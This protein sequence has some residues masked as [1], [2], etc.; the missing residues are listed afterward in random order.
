MDNNIDDYYEKKYLKYKQKY[1]KSV[2][3]KCNQNYTKELSNLCIKDSKGKYSDKT[4]CINKCTN[5]QITIS[6]ELRFSRLNKYKYIQKKLNNKYKYN[7]FEK[8]CIGKNITDIV[9]N[10]FISNGVN[11][12]VYIGTFNTEKKKNIYIAI[13]KQPLSIDE[14][15]SE[16]ILNSTFEPWAEIYAMKAGNKLFEQNITPHVS[17]LY[18]YFICDECTYENE[19]LREKSNNNC[20][21]IINELATSDLHYWRKQNHTKDEWYIMLFQIIYSLLAFQ[22]TYNLSHGDLHTK[23]ILYDKINSY[24][25]YNKY[26][27]FGKTIIIKNNMY[28]F[29]LYDFAKATSPNFIKNKNY[30]QDNI[31]K[32]RTK[33]I[34]K[35][36]DDLINN[37][38]DDPTII[39]PPEPIKTILHD[40]YKYFLDINEKTD[41]SIYINLLDNLLLYIG[42]KISS[43]SD[44]I[45]HTY[46][47][48]ERKYFTEEELSNGFNIMTEEIMSEKNKVIC[49]ICTF[50]NNQ[51]DT[52]CSICESPL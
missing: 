7:T 45:I 19:K 16:N 34:M 1:L 2:K 15:K 31:I 48:N 39:L 28:M 23:N 47:L 41:K 13:K 33:D 11:G 8:Y 26:I 30:S 35:L 51:S 24:N 14:S 20:L 21:Y 10:N 49:G 18:N 4:R 40:T 46:T 6:N 29:K 5:Y 36:F 38:Y 44:N 52:T 43:T 27:F 12:E 25:T 3:Y 32:H 22:Y 50:S 17:L 37:N 9:I 42:D